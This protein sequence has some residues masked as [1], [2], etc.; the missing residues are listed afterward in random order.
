MNLDELY[1][2]RHT[3]F[4]S[5]NWVFYS[6]TDI[7]ISFPH[8]VSH[9]TELTHTHIHIYIYTHTHTDTGTHTH[10]RTACDPVQF[11]QSSRSNTSVSASPCLI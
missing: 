4:L 10:T 8:S 7:Q 9:S 3:V 11:V 6:N 5:Q 2:R 1:D